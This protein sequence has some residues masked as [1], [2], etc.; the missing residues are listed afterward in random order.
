MRQSIASEQYIHSLVLRPVGPLSI[1]TRFARR[2]VNPFGTL[3]LRSPAF[4]A[5]CKVVYRYIFFPV[6]EFVTLK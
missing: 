3:G 4:L 5:V 2:Q 1:N 6:I